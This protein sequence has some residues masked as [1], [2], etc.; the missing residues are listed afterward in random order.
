MDRRGLALV[1]VMFGENMAKAIL[2]RMTISLRDREGRAYCVH[3][4]LQVS[5]VAKDLIF[6]EAYWSY[7]DDY[8]T[9]T[10]YDIWSDE[11]LFDSG[12]VHPIKH[13]GVGDS[14]RL[15]GGISL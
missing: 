12:G 9:V 5:R 1:I 11:E 8:F 15:E 10:D 14:L 3:Q 13:V 2:E 7:L 4:Q 6:F